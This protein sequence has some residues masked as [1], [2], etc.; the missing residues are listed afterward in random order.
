[1]RGMTSTF[2]MVPVHE[3]EA[4]RDDLARIRQLLEARQPEPSRHITLA[5]LAREAGL[6]IDAA[7]RMAR[8][9]NMPPGV[10][11]V[12]VGRGVDG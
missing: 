9:G 5:H 12:K 1:M 7:R 3:Y 6:E 2:I 10:E 8:A 11:A 4:M